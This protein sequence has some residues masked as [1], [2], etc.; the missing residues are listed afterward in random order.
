MNLFQIVFVPLCTIAALNNLWRLRRGQTSWLAG[1]FWF[2]VW[3]AGA[4]AIAYPPITS[5]A[6]R[7]FGITRG[8]DFVLYLVTLGLLFFLRVFYNRYRRLE[9][10][11]TQLAREIAISEA[12]EGP[13]AR[14]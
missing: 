10:M 12:V 3:T 7:T 9:N 6:A 13:R 8:S 11:V 5:L 1:L 4:V 14:T 2:V